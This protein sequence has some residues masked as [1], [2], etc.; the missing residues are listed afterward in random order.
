M[1]TLYFQYRFAVDHAS[2]HADRILVF[3]LTFF[4]KFM[5]FE[6]RVK[7]AAWSV[8]NAQIA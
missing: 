4:Y 3:L 2:P 8:D 7:D 5:L 6:F 1:F